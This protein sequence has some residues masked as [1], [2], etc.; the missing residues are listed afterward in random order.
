MNSL[1]ISGVQAALILTSIVGGAAG[2]HETQLPDFGPNV[3]IFNPSMSVADINAT[4]QSLATRSTG[5]DTIRNAVFFMPGTYGSAAGRNDPTT[6][7]DFI[8]SPVGF[9]ETVQGLG[10]SPDDVTING[11]LRVGAST[12]F[13]LATFWRS[14]SNV[15]INPIQ[16]DEPAHTMRWNTS[17][18]APVRRVDIVGNLDLA[19]GVGGGNLISNS[20][21]SGNVTAGFDWTTDPTPVGGQ[22][23]YYIHD[24][25]IGSFQGHF[26][27]FV[28]SGVK[29]APASQYN[30]GDVTAYKTTP[31][32][33]E[34]PFLYVDHGSFKVFV[35][36]S[37]SEVSGFHW[38]ARDRQAEGQHGNQD[39]RDGEND[40]YG[41]SLPLDQF[42]IAK[43]T[44]SS[45]AINEQLRRGKNLI[46][47]PGVYSVTES[48][49]VVRPNTIIMGLG[50]ATITPTSGTAAIHVDNVP[51]VSISAITVDA[52]TV[53]SAVLVQVGTQGAKA[54]GGGG[55]GANP[56]TLS[57]VFIRV[58]GSYAGHATTSV[59]V[60][61]DDVLI[62]YIWA[63]RADHGNQGTTGW[64]V[65]TG[66]HGLV[67]NGDKVTALGLFVEHYQQTQVVWNGDAGRT[68]F[69]QSEAPYDPPN[70]SAYMNG[71]EDG[72]PYYEIGEHV[73]S[74]EASGMS[75][76]TLFIYSPTPIYIH[77]AYKAPVRPD[78]RLHHILGEVLLGQ[79]GIQNI[80][81]DDGITAVS[82]DPSFLL[83]VGA[84]T[85]LTAFP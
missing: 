55:D 69:L 47:T 49:H 22:F 9:M 56:T 63:W 32:S 1:K 10:A 83:N 82:G 67:V 21:I 70:Q 28:F 34:A 73:R 43:P 5:F 25:Q 59:E 16:A 42:F 80:V 58:G 17:Q 76:A 68:I 78:V 23:Y 45:A 8:D 26:A 50:L 4:L 61:Q 29:G 84:T 14:L 7:S 33:R 3:T 74:H 52:N 71:T 72:Y 81:N 75:V 15:K 27:N 64:T 44:D 54:R 20:R 85:Q 6:A 31:I 2:S 35:P 41:S 57:D 37:R 12:G 77:S 46:L 65:N 53:N 13:A 79:G 11:N 66:A 60:N 18:A 40:C 38:G 36:D 51:G 19:G 24:S 48:I 62:D 39:G 30:P